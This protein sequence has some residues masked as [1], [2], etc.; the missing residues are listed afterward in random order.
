MNLLFISLFSCHQNAGNLT[1]K[2]QSAVKSIRLVFEWTISDKRN[3]QWWYKTYYAISKTRSFDL[4]MFVS[5][6]EKY[7]KYQVNYFE[8]HMNY[9]IS[10]EKNLIIM[11]FYIEEEHLK[12]ALGF[13]IPVLLFFIY[14]SVSDVINYVIFVI[15]CVIVDVFMV[16]RLK[17]TLDEKLKWYDK[18]TSSVKFEAKKKDNEEAVNKLIKLVVLNT[19]LGVL[20]KLPCSFISIVDLYASFYY[21]NQV[22]PL[23]N[24]AFG[25]FFSYLLDSGFFNLIVDI[26][27]FLFVLSVA[28]QFFYLQ[29]LW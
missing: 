22:N 29:T 1:V 16:V 18:E 27:E 26:Y 13:K 20:C 19:S 4:T 25:K 7:F 24:P 21:R 14:N 11:I 8:P 3:Q 9:P 15:I 2:N 17:R 6:L 10:N 23:R 28:I 5:L 12:T